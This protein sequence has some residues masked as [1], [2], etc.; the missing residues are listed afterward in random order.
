MAPSLSYTPQLT[1]Q[2]KQQ[3]MFNMSQYLNKGM[4]PRGGTRP[5]TYQEF[6]AAKGQNPFGAQPQGGVDISKI[7]GALDS[8]GG[9][10]IGL[11]TLAGG[12]AAGY[13]ATQLLGGGGAAALGQGTAGSILGTSAA[14]AGAA[15]APTAATTGAALG[16]MGGGG[17]GAAGIGGA[18]AGAGIGAAGGAA[19]A[20]LLTGASPLMTAAVPLAF[21][22]GTA[23]LAPKIAKGGEKLG[24]L[25]GIGDNRPE[26][27][28]KA[29][30][31]IQS[32]RLGGQLPGFD[33]LSDAEKQQVTD[34]ANAL[35]ML[36]LP[37]SA[38]AQGNTVDGQGMEFIK[39]KWMNF[40]YINDIVN[41]EG[42]GAQ[43]GLASRKLSDFKIPANL[44]NYARE[45][46]ENMVNMVGPKEQP[47]GIRPFDIRNKDGST[48]PSSPQMIPVASSQSGASSG[49]STQKGSALQGI[50]NALPV[51]GQAPA[52][53]MI[54]KAPGRSPGFNAKGQRINYSK[55]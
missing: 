22:A 33:K 55:K 6:L 45:N 54:P 48:T 47:V 41:K 12:G 38:D 46:W 31:A 24:R 50:A 15:L 35:G 9:G 28:Y 39:P 7:A 8:K 30:E 32:K 10:G 21:L 14:G 44:K 52:P 23:A 27:V 2:Q 36:R 4:P 25:M 3:M 40:D 19:P 18:T 49:N 5:L 42:K 13:G 37:G 17:I 43:W 34:R 16:G 1:P 51:I 53:I 29:S 20:G 11:G 26:R